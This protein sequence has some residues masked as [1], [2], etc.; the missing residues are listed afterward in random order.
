M[1]RQVR[2]EF[3]NYKK[4]IFLSKPS[5]RAICSPNITDKVFTKSEKDSIEENPSFGK[6][7]LGQ[8]LVNKF[9]KPVLVLAF[10]NPTFNSKEYKNQEELY[11]PHMW[12]Y[13]A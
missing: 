11:Y 7:M 5:S 10:C 3:I 6:K 2:T 8:R 12:N 4:T 1:G 9:K 13:P